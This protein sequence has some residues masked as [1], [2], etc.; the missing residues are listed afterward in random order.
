M[1]ESEPSLHHYQIQLTIDLSGYDQQSV[2][3]DCAT[4]QQHLLEAMKLDPTSPNSV[5][6][7]T[8][9]PLLQASSAC[10]NH[11]NVQASPSYGEKKLVLSLPEPCKGGLYYP[12]SGVKILYDPPEDREPSWLRRL[13]RL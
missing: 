1:D 4:L 5:R 10:T 2:L 12:D 6:S 8:L 13:L 3:R 7:Y 11:T 9:G